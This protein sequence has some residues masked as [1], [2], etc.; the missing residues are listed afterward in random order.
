M[1]SS[2]RINK[3]IS[4]LLA[5]QADVLAACPHNSE[6][7]SSTT[8]VKPFKKIPVVSKYYLIRGFL[9][10]GEFYGKSLSDFYKI[11]Q[12]KYGDIFKFPG[13]FGKRDII[14]TFNPDDFAMVYRTEG[15]WP[16]RDGLDTLVYHR[17]V[18]HADFFGS[19]GG[20]SIE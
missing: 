3:V 20:L 14:M 4:R 2:L 11:T 6:T 19:F 16:F 18:R 1:I 5:T 7:Q 13:M 8:N 15:V 17:N 10:G 9:P 12:N